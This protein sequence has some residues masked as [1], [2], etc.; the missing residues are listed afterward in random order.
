ME[1]L[2]IKK[3]GLRVLIWAEVRP[4][5]KSTWD[6]DI[7]LQFYLAFK[8]SKYQIRVFYVALLAQQI[9]CRTQQQERFRS[10]VNIDTLME[11]TS[12][13]QSVSLKLP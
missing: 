3:Y 4:L 5:M 11:P 2:K 6:L 12:T 1:I 9:I 8:L 13:H 10:A 7:D